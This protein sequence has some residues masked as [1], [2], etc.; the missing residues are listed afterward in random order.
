MFIYDEYEVF[1]LVPYEE[2]ERYLQ[3]HDIVFSKFEVIL[4]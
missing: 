3:A 2:K 4:N 1:W